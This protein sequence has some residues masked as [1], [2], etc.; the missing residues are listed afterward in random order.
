LIIFVYATMAAEKRKFTGFETF[1]GQII[2]GMYVFPKL[3]KHS[4]TGALREWCIYVRLIKESSKS[5]ATTHK[6]NWNLLL[7]D[8]IAIKPEYLKDDGA[9]PDGVLSQIWTE[10]GIVEGKISRAQPTYPEAKNVGKKNERNVL[11]QA[12][13]EARSKFLHQKKLGS[14]EKEQL[15]AADKTSAAD[16]K[17]FPMLA[18]VYQKFIATKELKYPLYV[19]PKLDGNRCIAYLAALPS[20]VEENK[21]DHTDVT[22]YS[23]KR[24]DFPVNRVTDAIRMAL[25]D[26]LVEN[27]DQES[28][29]S[30]Y[31]DGELYI[32]GVPLQSISSYIKRE[33][34]RDSDPDVEYHVY[35]MFYPSY[36]DVPFERRTATLAAMYNSLDPEAKKLIKLVP[37]HKVMN[38]QENDTYYDKYLDEKYEGTMI[39]TAKGKYAKSAVKAEQRSNDLLKRKETY[40]GEFE[41]V[42]FKDGSIGK[43]VGALIW[44][45]ITKQKHEFNVVPN[46]T[47]DERYA[48]FKDCQKHFVAKYKNRMLTV[49]Y[50]SLSKD[51]IPQH[52]KGIAFRLDR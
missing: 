5:K 48:M 44:I 17:F 21:V 8:Q 28:E 2:S 43:D 23:R 3:F 39:R 9:L 33:K 41:V 30:V 24:L 52:A 32:H 50:R 15:S 10:S 29:E 38:Q 25:V 1:P 47:Y 4:K 6:Q 37:T 35:D 36:E 31:L 34:S 19:Q 14:A 7:E 49:E 22:L 45:C 20:H 42:G 13:T 12:L 26:M 11:H 16:T 51:K 46:M 40:D 27:Y 18:H